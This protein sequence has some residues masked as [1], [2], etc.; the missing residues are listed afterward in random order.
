MHLGLQEGE[1]TVMVSASSERLMRLG[2]LSQGSSHL[3]GNTVAPRLGEWEPP[4]GHERDP[5]ILC[6][7]HVPLRGPR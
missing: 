6:T 3:G 5:W 4:L 7:I 1:S 2:P